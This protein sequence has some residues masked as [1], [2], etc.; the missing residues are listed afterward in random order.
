[1]PG[2]NRLDKK[3]SDYGYTGQTGKLKV[4]KSRPDS[5]LF[6]LLFVQIL[7]KLLESVVVEGKRVHRIDIEF[8]VEID[9]TVFKI[10]VAATFRGWLLFTAF[11]VVAAVADQWISSCFWRLKPFM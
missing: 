10:I 1:L 9:P 11:V 7:E 2:G 3:V 4:K 8:I 5:L 6:Q